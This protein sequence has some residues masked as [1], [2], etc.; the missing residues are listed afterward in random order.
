MDSVSY[1]EPE[2]R[3]WIV[4]RLEDALAHAGGTHHFY[5][6][7]IPLLQAGKAQWWERG[8]GVCITELIDMPEFRQL[9]IWL[10]AG[11]LPDLLAMQEPIEQWAAANGVAR[12][13]GAGRD[14][15][16]RVCVKRMGFERT[17]VTIEKWLG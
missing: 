3:S 9:N 6:D 7:V 13:V 4:N 16:G 15:W 5:R 11:R 17:G 14:G 12:I 8:D 2:R 1:R 10:A